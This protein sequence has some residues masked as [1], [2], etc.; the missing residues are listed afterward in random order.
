MPPSAALAG[1][2]PRTALL[3]YYSFT[4]ESERAVELAAAA[5]AQQGWSSTSLRVDFADTSLRLRR[6]LAP[7]DVKRWT[8]A[9]ERGDT[10]PVQLSPETAL[11]AR[12][13]L[14]CLFSNTWQH[15]P[16]VPIRSLLRS[17]A[18]K[19][20]LDGTPLAVYVVCRRSWERNLG[21]VRAEAEAQ[22]AR[23]VGGEG[24]TH[25]GS[26]VGSLIRTVSYLMSSGGRIARC[27][28][29]PLPL[30]AYGLSA[31]ATARVSRF[32]QEMAQAAGTR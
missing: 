11:Q 15:H 4:G 29:I 7:R 24:F 17:G 28:G 1:A 20:V 21:I 5:L 26:Q 31:A 8:Q 16:C 32:T 14:V 18:L 23:F 6:P 2:P 27:L 9:A 13:G 10:L 25:A 12:Y 19:P 3:V 30:P 22:G